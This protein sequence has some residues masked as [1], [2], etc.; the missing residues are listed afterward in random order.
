MRSYLTFNQILITVFLTTVLSACITG[1]TSPVATS[2]PVGKSMNVMVL[3][4][5]SDRLI[6]Q[7]N[8]PS[9]DKEIINHIC[10]EMVWIIRDN[11]VDRSKEEIK[12]IIA[13]QSSIPY[14][15]MA[16]TDSLYFN[17]DKEI[18]GGIPAVKKT[19]VGRFARNLDN[20]Y[21]TAVYSDNPNEYAGANL[22][23]Y[24]IR[25][26]K[27]DVREDS[28]TRNLLFILTDG[29][30]VVGHKSN[31]MLEIHR[32]FPDLEIMVLEI[33]PRSKDYESERIIESWDRWFVDIGI[34]GYLLR[35]IGPIEAI[36]EDVSKFLHNDIELISPGTTDQL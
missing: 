33:A 12:I 8:Q 9:R 29:Y 20:L 18:R 19:M 22:A 3:L 34:K 17:M 15:I 25:D 23:R 2:E 11:G 10:S 21:K 30:V 14:S 31:A 24:F 28:L 26:L 13:D 5:L 1:G 7:A 6:V 4:D 16:Y 35:N 32:A 27:N 36:K